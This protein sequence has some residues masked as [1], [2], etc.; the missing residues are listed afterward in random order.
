MWVAIATVAIA[1]FFMVYFR[2]NIRKLIDRFK[3]GRAGNYGVDCS[4]VPSQTAE[5]IEVDPAKELMDSFNS[6]LVL[7][8]ENLIREELQKKGIL[9]DTKKAA[10]VLMRYMAALQVLIDFQNIDSL[11]W[12]SQLYILEALNEIKAG[13]SKEHIKSSYY[14]KAKEKFPEQYYE[15]SYEQYIQFLITNNLLLEQEG[16]YVI[17]VKGVEFMRYLVA[18]GKSGARYRPG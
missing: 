4:G 17:T 16:K 10:E 1:I 15:Y 12:G 2:K 13:L 8:R 14:D 5:K 3:G 7:E 11:I 9:T 6:P 18:I